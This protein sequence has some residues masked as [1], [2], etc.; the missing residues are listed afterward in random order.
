MEQK[1]Q[2]IIILVATHKKYR[3]P[4]DEIYLPL[5][6]GR[7]GKE[8]LGYAGDNTGDNISEKN[9]S[10][11][12]LTGLYWGWKNLDCNYMG[13]VQ[14]RRHFMY[15]RK[16]SRFQSI[17]NGQEARIILSKHD[18]I[19]PK[20]R[21][22]R[23]C[24]LEEHFENYD[25]SIPED[26]KNLRKAIQK[27]SPDYAAAV[28]TVMHRKKGHMCNMFVMKKNYL[29]QFC[30]WE[31]SVL[32]EF[33]KTVSAERKRIVGYVAEHMLDIWITK[34]NLS[35]FECDVALLDV[36]NEIDRRIDFVMRK[37]GL[38]YRRIHLLPSK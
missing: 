23:V 18:I 16:G 17:L 29:N 21:N 13:L 35:Y 34:N 37:L 2:D 12:E 11:C 5:H 14:Y 36:K 15:Q 38:R 22:Y 20:A 6:V 27:I 26:L 31:F 9:S 10:W 30:A 25:M 19:L 7:A 32:E 1:K 33:E 3:M 8:D 4:G 28:E 24:T